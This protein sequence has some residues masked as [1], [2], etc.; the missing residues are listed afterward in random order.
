[1]GNAIE[2]LNRRSYSI[3]AIFHKVALSTAD[4]NKWATLLNRGNSTPDPQVTRFDY[5]RTGPIRQ[6]QRRLSEAQ[7]Q[8]MADKYRSGANVYQLAKK[9]GISRH[10]VS[11]RIKKAG[12][13]MRQQSPKSELI[14]EM[15]GLYES[16]LSLAMAGNRLGASPGTVRRYLL[17]RGIKMRDSHGR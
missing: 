11:E 2:L 13:E 1:M 12:V 3:F 16:G 15:V 4:T 14:D 6:R 8:L 7:A 10:T 17:T 9:F 5:E